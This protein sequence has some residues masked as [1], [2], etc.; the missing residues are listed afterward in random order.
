M[1]TVVY[2]YREHKNNLSKKNDNHQKCN[3]SCPR[4]VGIF[5]LHYHRNRR[6]EN[7]L[8]CRTRNDIYRTSYSYVLNDV[9]P[10]EGLKSKKWEPKKN[11]NLEEDVYDPK[12]LTYDHL[13]AFHTDAVFLHEMEMMIKNQG[14]DNRRSDEKSGKVIKM[15]EEDNRKTK[16][17]EKENNQ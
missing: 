14:K 11:K 6:A 3:I 9:K 2:E 17:T 5:L 4:K 8:L 7:H 10:K 15:K 12:D 1:E 16:Q 13:T